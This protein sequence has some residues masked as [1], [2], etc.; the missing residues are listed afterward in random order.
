[1]FLL[2]HSFYDKQAS[3][4]NKIKQSLNELN[5]FPA[6]CVLGLLVK[7][8]RLMLPRK[9]AFN[10]VLQ[11][12]SA[13]RPLE[14]DM[15]NEFRTSVLSRSTIW[16]DT[17]VNRLNSTKMSTHAVNQ[18]RA[19]CLIPGSELQNVEPLSKV[20]VLLVQSSINSGVKT[21]GSLF[22]GWDLIVPE[23]WAMAFW[24]TLVHLGARAVAQ[25]ELN[26]L[27]FESGSFVLMP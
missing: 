21:C 16:D 23:T 14:T 20:P 9:K 25:E 5:D 3:I 12:K 4:W 24:L 13:G 22:A 15:K 8:P 1:M 7:D 26:Y 17:F 19:K 2:R 10:K 6:S 18:L 27:L 11:S